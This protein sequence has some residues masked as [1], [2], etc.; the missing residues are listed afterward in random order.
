MLLSMHSRPK[1]R[2]RFNMIRQTQPL[3]R[4]IVALLAL[5]MA[6]LLMVNIATFV[7]VKKTSDY[8]D[9]A[10]HSKQVQ[11]SSLELLSLLT[12]AETSQRGYLLTVQPVYL[13]VYEDAH[14]RVPE[15]L[16]RLDMLAEDDEAIKPRV[17]RLRENYA[18]RKALMEKSLVLARAGQIEEAMV[19]VQAGHGKTVMDEIRDDVAAIVAYEDDRVMTLMERS[20][21]AQAYTLASN[22]V[23]T[24]LLVVVGIIGAILVKRHVQTLTRAQKELDAVNIGL[25]EEVRERTKEVVQA[26]EEIQRFAY[27]VSHDLRAPL[28]N[29]MGYTSELEQIGLLLDDQLKRLEVE[30]PEQ[31]NAEAVQAVRVDTPEA[32]GFIRASTAKMDGLIKAILALSREGRRP[33]AVEKLDM[34]SLVQGLADAV[35]HPIV[36]GGGHI[37]VGNLPNIH[38]DRLSIEQIFGNLIDNATKYR[39]PERPLQLTVIG[40]EVEGDWVEFDVIDNGRGIDPKDHERIFELFRRAGKQDKAGEG[41][42]LAFV[43]SAVRRLGGSVTVESQLGEGARFILRFPRKMIVRSE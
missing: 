17:G 4:A 41:L 19:H 29:I 26:N 14:H 2:R 39:S 36:E 5:A 43:R 20:Q 21:R 7:M 8:N 42:G 11:L 33:L 38:S 18:T 35:A 25:E 22:L 1:A 16:D 30:A 28:V 6:L 37:D 40:R 12:D 9:T 34:R 31:V 3:N 15:V 10:T 23:G 13:V 32:V 24:L 27:I